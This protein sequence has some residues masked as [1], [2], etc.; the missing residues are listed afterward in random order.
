VVGSEG[1]LIEQEQA[2]GDGQHLL[3]SGTPTTVRERVWPI[4]DHASNNRVRF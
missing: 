1:G 3:L 2:G 4:P